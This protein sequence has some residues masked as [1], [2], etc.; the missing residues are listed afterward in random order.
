MGDHAPGEV[1]G[2]GED[3]AKKWTVTPQPDGTFEVKCPGFGVKT[4]SSETEA[5][6]HIRKKFRIGDKVLRAAD[7]G[8]LTP[9]TRSITR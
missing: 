3:V 2:V 8:Y 5:L 4:V 1:R 9:I 7:D 6:A